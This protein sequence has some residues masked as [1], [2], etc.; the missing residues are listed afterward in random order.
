MDCT[1]LECKLLSIPNLH[2]V[3]GRNRETILAF[4]RELSLGDGAV[5]NLVDAI[6]NR[7]FHNHMGV[8]GGQKCRG[9]KEGRSQRHDD[10]DDV[11]NGI[12]KEC[13]LNQKKLVQ[14]GRRE[15]CKS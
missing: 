7:L 11:G 13:D 1:A 2:R 4:A 15:G 12:S 3:H 5:I 6:R 14:L 8:G 9:G 10:D